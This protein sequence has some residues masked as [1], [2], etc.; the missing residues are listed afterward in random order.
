V[1]QSGSLLPHFIK[2]SLLLD[3]EDSVDFGLQASV[4]DDKWLQ[5]IRSHEYS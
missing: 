5:D 2:P 4:R 1:G 3:R